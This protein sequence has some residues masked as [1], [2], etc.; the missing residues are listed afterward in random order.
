MMRAQINKIFII[1]SNKLYSNEW[2][3]ET[4][5]QSSA[6]QLTIKN[7]ILIQSIW[8]ISHLT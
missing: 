5:Y 8:E 1:F 2:P 6:E 4:L 3:Q 7:Y